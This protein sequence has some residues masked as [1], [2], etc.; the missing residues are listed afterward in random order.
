MRVIAAF[1]QTRRSADR[2]IQDILQ[3][4]NP[5]I[6]FLIMI[7]VLELKCTLMSGDCLDRMLMQ[8]RVLRNQSC[9]TFSV[10][11]ACNNTNVSMYIIKMNQDNS[12]SVFHVKI[13]QRSV[14]PEYSKVSDILRYMFC[15]NLDINSLNRCQFQIVVTKELVAD[16]DP[17]VIPESTFTIIKL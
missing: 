4:C 1:G 9:N 12:R 7:F 8:V 6:A 11:F 15:K 14:Q 17:I 2:R 5:L 10:D 16:G 13:S 3:V